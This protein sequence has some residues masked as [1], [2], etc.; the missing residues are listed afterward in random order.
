MPRPDPLQALRLLRRLELE[1][2]RR[3]FA[4]KLRAEGR[5]AEALGQV[6]QEL[7]VEA[8]SAAADYAAWLPA[9]R[10]RLEQA[11]VLHANTRVALTVAQEA[12]AAASRAEQLVLQDAAR[13]AQERRAA[14]HARAD[15]LLGDLSGRAL[16][17][18]PA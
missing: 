2:A 9:A 10:A 13:R 18:P 4:G 16:K 1:D 12:V 14:R 17:P 15:R 3:G 11:A 7:A 8:G 5:A 6:A